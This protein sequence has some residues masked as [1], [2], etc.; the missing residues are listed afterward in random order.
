MTWSLQDTI[1]QGT[2]ASGT[3]PPETRPATPAHTPVGDAALP[4]IGPMAH[5]S[6][7]G[8]EEL[9]H[10]PLDVRHAM[11]HAGMCPDD[12]WQA[13]GTLMRRGVVEI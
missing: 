10:Y 3:P 5:M 4:T 6:S 11:A 8:D 2:R 7:E 13:L 9:A 12:V 1:T